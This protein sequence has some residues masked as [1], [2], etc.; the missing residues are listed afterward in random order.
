MTL[1]LCQQLTTLNR[2]SFNYDSNEASS[3]K[4]SPLT[5]WL[6]SLRLPDG[7]QSWL[8][9]VAKVPYDNTGG[10]T[11]RI[12]TIGHDPILGLIFGVIDII[13]GTSTS[14]KDGIIVIEKVSVVRI[15][16]KQL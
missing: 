9:N 8:E 13:R 5:K 4:G 14:L 7:L 6:Q 3:K 12:D 2:Y 11:H 1:N 16:L 10:S 15:L